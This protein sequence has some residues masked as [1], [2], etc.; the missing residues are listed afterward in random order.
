[1]F[2]YDPSALM[3]AHY[4]RQDRITVAWY[5]DG[6]NDALM[7]KLPVWS[8]DAYLAGYVAGIK[9]LPCNQSG[10]ILYQNVP[11]DVNEEF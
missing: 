4:E 2:D 1:M 7:G 5:D 11:S 8:D 6:L 9:Q 3:Q 10:H